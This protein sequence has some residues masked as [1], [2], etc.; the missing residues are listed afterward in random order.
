MRRGRPG[1]P[2][3]QSDTKFEQFHRID[4]RINVINAFIRKINSP[5]GS[6]GA[7][8]TQTNFKIVK[9]YKPCF[10]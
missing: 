2:P 8:R 1:A 7:L 3:P 9:Y 10:I 4:K 6:Q 5:L